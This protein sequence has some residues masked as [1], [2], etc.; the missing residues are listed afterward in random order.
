MSNSEPKSKFQLILAKTKYPNTVE[1]MALDLTA[2]GVKEGDVAI[3]HSSLSSIGWVCNDQSAVV[4]ALIKAFGTD[5][6]IVMPAH[7]SS[8]YDPAE[9]ENPPIPKEWHE[10]VRQSIPA[11]DK[12]ITP[13]EF[14]G[15]IA[16]CFRCF[17][18]TLRSDHPIHSFTARG[19]IA[20]QII[21]THVLTPCFGMDTPLGELYRL[22]AKVLLLGA[23][24]SS[25]TVFHLA[26]VLSD[27]PGMIKQGCAI[28]E[29]GKWI[30]KWYEDFDCDSGDFQQIGEAFEA[31]GLVHCGKVGNAD[32]KL[33][34]VK[35]AVDFALEWIV[36][37]R[38]RG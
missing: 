4:L 5:D 20:G 1:S 9:W 29:N 37:N 27:L 34:D 8:N 35:P 15:V 16:E 32:C 2:L 26:E 23:P 14:M 24:Y 13:S 28:Y 25:C 10:T 19:K 33:F 18:G 7:T 3:V 38:S 22:N 30:W 31:V 11:Y 6:T 17:P 21:G 12:N 36:K